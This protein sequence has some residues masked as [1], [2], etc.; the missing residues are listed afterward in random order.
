MPAAIKLS[1]HDQIIARCRD[2][3]GAFKKIGLEDCSFT[4]N[5]N[6]GSLARLEQGFVLWRSFQDLHKVRG[7]TYKTSNRRLYG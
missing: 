6:G 5:G 3:G 1:R 4:A 7:K 2:T